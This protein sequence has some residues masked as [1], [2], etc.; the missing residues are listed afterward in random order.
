MTVGPPPTP[1][2]PTTVEPSAGR[3]LASPLVAIVGYTLRACLPAKRWFGVLLPC[4]GALLFGLLTLVLD[5]DPTTIESEDTTTFGSGDTDATDAE[6]ADAVVLGD[7]ADESNFADVAEMGLFALVLP[8]A[9]LVVGD[10]VLGADARAGS[11]Q[12]TWLS[13]VSFGTIAFGRWLGGWLVTLVTLVPALALAPVIA[14]VPDAAGPMALAGA[15]GAGAYLALFMMI[16]VVTRRS[17]LWS[18]AIVLL[19]E[20]L[21]GTQLSGVAQVS[22]LWEAQQLFAGLWEHGVLIERDGMPLGWAAA[23]RLVLVA[24]VCLGVATWRLG[25]MRPITSAD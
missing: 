3:P 10:A 5:D 16:G 1:A 21:L 13:P 11:F 18:L 8:L 9:C 17:A 15:F 24:A 2:A 7:L 22:P 12:L 25:R 4:L 6:A 14:G 19:G 20:W 23:V